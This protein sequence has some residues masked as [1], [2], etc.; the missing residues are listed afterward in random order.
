MSWRSRKQ[1]YANADAADVI[2][3][4]GA[5]G[6]YRI[7][8][9][10]YSRCTRRYWIARCRHATSGMHHVPSLM[11]LGGPQQTGKKRMFPRAFRDCGK[12]S[13][14]K[15]ERN[16]PNA[17]VRTMSTSATTDVS[18]VHGT[19]FVGANG[20]SRRDA[21]RPS[22]ESAVRPGNTTPDWRRSGRKAEL[23]VRRELRARVRGMRSGPPHCEPQRA[24]FPPDPLPSVNT[25]GSRAVRCAHHAA[26]VSA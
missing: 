20:Q 5:D 13:T 18:R 26:G 17:R 2:V 10:R 19:A 11:W 6:G 1:N 4:V 15:S 7:A 22:P 21:P 12:R 3:F 25:G 23:A 24:M 9:R 16:S 8:R 14:I